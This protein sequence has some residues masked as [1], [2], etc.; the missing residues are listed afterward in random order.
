MTFYKGFHEVANVYKKEKRVIFISTGC[1]RFFSIW[2]AGPDP[3]K[4][5]YRRKDFF[6]F[7][8]GYTSPSPVFRDH[9]KER[10]SRAREETHA[11]SLGGHHL[12]FPT[13]PPGA[14][15]KEKKPI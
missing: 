1:N 3:G 12:V 11:G 14:R 10:S 4:P 2:D 6:S 7:S 15:Q 8:A 13:L 9:E 5:K